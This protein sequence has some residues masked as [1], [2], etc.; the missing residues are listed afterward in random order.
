M[1]SEDLDLSVLLLALP[2]LLLEPREDLFLPVLRDLLVGEVEVFDA[3]ARQRTSIV[4]HSAACSASRVRRWPASQTSKAAQRGRKGAV[5]GFVVGVGLI[6]VVVVAA[7]VA[8]VA[9]V[10]V[11]VVGLAVVGVL[12]SLEFVFVGGLGLELDEEAM[13]DAAAGV[14]VPLSGG[15]GS[16]FVSIVSFSAFSIVA[17]SVVSL[18]V[19]VVSFSFTAVA[20]AG[21]AF[22]FAAL[23]FPRFGAISVSALIHLSC[24]YTLCA[25]DVNAEVRCTMYAVDYGVGIRCRCR[26]YSCA[27][28]IGCFGQRVANDSIGKFRR[29]ACGVRRRRLGN[30][31]A[32]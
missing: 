32:G 3:S 23:A 28:Y 12:V 7:A 18:V 11:L 16:D 31:D 19:V 24:G 5:D 14:S 30:S 21:A 29:A 9:E 4:A 17:V 6:V 27:G 25:E 15:A 13:V 26:G 10:A 2:A 8:E 20:F 1:S 22:A